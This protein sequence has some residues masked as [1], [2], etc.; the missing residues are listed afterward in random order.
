MAT[1]IDI[2]NRALLA[3]G[4]R[5]QVSSISP[6]DGSTEA[7]VAAVLYTPTFETLAREAHWNCLRKQTFLTL[8]QAAP[9]TPENVSGTSMP[10]PP[11]PWNYAYALP[12]D[13]LQVRQILPNMT[14]T[15]NVA[16]TPVS[17]A[18]PLYLPNDMALKFQVALS[19]DPNGN[20][21]QVILTYIDQAQCVYT[22]NLP[23][24]QFWDSTFQMAMVASLSAA[25]VP[26]LSLHMGLMQ[27]Q[28]ALAER[29]VNEARVRD[30]N[31]GVTSQD[32]TPD[33]LRV[34]GCGNTTK[35]GW[36]S[37]YAGFQVRGWGGF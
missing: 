5:A 16:P 15:P 21:I 17:I 6:S 13:C 32:H 33:W 25:F 12:P 30:G 37:A 9:G 10:T 28:N 35:T 20:P 29:L 27:G 26:A 1:Q 2:V 18:A 31:E 11:Q 14:Q 22:A 7:D 24:P 3:I 4:A 19:Y 8:L 34:R 23:N 36:D